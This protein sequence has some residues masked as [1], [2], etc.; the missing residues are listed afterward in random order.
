LYFH[1]NRRLACVAAAISVDC[2]PD[3]RVIL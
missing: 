2:F 1:F 3:F